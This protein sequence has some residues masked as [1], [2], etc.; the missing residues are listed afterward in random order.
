MKLFKFTFKGYSSDKVENA[1]KTVLIVAKTT[2]KAWEEFS[3][4]AKKTQYASTPDDYF[5]RCEVVYEG[6]RLAK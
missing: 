5:A 4:F 3:R 1:T 2:I 6:L